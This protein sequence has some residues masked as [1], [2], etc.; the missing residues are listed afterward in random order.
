V[1]KTDIYSV[2]RVARFLV[3]YVVFCRSLFVHLSFFLL[4]VTLYVLLRFTASLV[5]SNISYRKNGLTVLTERRPLECE[6]KTGIRS[7]KYDMLVPLLSC[8]SISCRLI[9]RWFRFSSSSTFMYYLF[10]LSDVRL[11]QKR[12][13]RT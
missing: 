6:H 5:S 7:F 9:F 8:E 4:G 13:V 2:V 3:F 1:I 10:K 12:F 11:F